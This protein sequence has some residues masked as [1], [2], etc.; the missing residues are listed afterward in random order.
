MKLLERL[1]GKKV[2]REEKPSV[3]VAHATPNPDVTVE[4]QRCILISKCMEVL[5]EQLEARMRD[6]SS[7]ACS[8]SCDFPGTKNKAYLRIIPD[9]ADKSL[10]RLTAN[11]VREG[12]DLCV[13]NY[14]YKGTRQE[15]KEWLNDK[16]RVEE[17]IQ[18]IAHLSESLDEKMD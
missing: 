12:S 14:L 18:Y 17:L 3:P 15:M 5:L 8:V 13:M 7:A 2:V 6:S 4:K 11:L 10:C 16:N 9:A 1:F